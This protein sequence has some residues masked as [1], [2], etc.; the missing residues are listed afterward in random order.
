MDKFLE[1]IAEDAEFSPNEILKD[2]SE[3]R[4]EDQLTPPTAHYPKS[5]GA[6]LIRK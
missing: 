1:L 2:T 3:T 6:F 4:R 5:I